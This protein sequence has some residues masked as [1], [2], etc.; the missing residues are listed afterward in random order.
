[1]LEIDAAMDLLAFEPE[2]DEHVS[3]VHAVHAVARR[4]DELECV[5]VALELAGQGEVGTVLRDSL[6][7]MDERVMGGPWLADVPPLDDHDPVLDAVSWNDPAAWW[8]QVV[9]T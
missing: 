8:G 7:V 3:R 5:A 9:G 2:A 1:M 4:R 6:D